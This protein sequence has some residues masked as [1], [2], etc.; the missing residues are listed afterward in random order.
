MELLNRLKHFIWSEEEDYEEENDL[1]EAH[2]APFE[3]CVGKVMTVRPD[4]YVNVGQLANYL[5][6]GYLVL[7]DLSDVTAETARRILDFLS[8]AA[9]SRDGTLTQISS[10][11]YLLAPASVEMRD[12]DM[13]DTDEWTLD[14]AFNF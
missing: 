2:V 5:C 6:A 1:A 10:K 7:M 13:A 11:A 3:P 4:E 8:G 12:C 14:R 9:Y